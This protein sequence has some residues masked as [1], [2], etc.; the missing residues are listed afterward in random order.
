MFLEGQQPIGQRQIFDVE[1]LSIALERG[2]IFAV[3]IDHHDMALRRQLADAV[4]DQREA[5]RL[6]GAG[7]AHQREMA[8]EQRV[9]IERAA[10]V[11]GGIDGAD[12][13]VR[14]VLGGEDLQHVGMAGG[15][16]DAPRH[17]IARHAAAEIE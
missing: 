5:G 3:R 16:D 12:L 14:A 8:A 4:E 7:R 11:G 10:H 2:R 9:D 17:R 15:M 6:A 1:Q 13:D